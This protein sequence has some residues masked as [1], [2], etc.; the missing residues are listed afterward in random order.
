MS[1]ALNV[2]PRTVAESIPATAIA[3]PNWVSTP[4]VVL[5]IAEA[6]CPMFPVLR[7]PL[8]TAYVPNQGR[9]PTANPMMK[10]V[11][12][13]LQTELPVIDAPVKFGCAG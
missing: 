9:E 6:P 12:G 3:S 2:F 8:I 11:L 13:L 5:F 4:A 10:W 7:T 1:V